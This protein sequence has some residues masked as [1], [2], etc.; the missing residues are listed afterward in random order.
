[1]ADLCRLRTSWTG[2]QGAPYLSTIYFARVDSTTASDAADAVAALWS[3]CAADI[4]ST[5]A[6]EVEPDVATIDDVTGALV[7]VDNISGGHAGN[8]TSTQESLPFATQGLLRLASNTVVS[9]RI[10]K[11]HLFIPG[12]T[13]NVGGEGTPTSGYKSSVLAAWA[14]LLA[15]GPAIPVIWSRKHGVSAPV[16]SASVW[17]QWAVLRSRRD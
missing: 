5:L 16:L 11:G 13:E 8:G 1:M 10:L 12:P 15:S 7:G 2:L 4:R 6:W 9:G 14:D 17:A 3:G